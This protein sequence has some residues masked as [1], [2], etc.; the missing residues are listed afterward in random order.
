MAT[1]ATVEAARTT[2]GDEDRKR[3]SAY[4]TDDDEVVLYCPVCAEREFAG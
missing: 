4:L 3:W 1:M 2:P